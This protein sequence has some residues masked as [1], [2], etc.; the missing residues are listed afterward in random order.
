MAHTSHRPTPARRR[1]VE[2]S[3]FPHDSDYGEYTGADGDPRN[4]DRTAADIY[5]EE[6]ML[7]RHAQEMRAARQQ[8][9]KQQ[10][11]SKP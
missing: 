8:I 1:Y 7:T 5:E 11:N 2:P 9:H 6:V 10:E 3:R 4:D